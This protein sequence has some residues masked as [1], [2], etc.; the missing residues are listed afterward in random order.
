MK[1]LGH[2]FAYPGGLQSDEKTETPLHEG[3]TKREAFAAIALQGLL[4]IY[5]VKEDAAIQAVR[6]AD[7]LIE[8]LNAKPSR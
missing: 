8:A 2:D 1:T 3:F 7:A 5:G 6:Q 4:Q